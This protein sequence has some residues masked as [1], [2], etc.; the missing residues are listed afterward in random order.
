MALS[1]YGQGRLLDLKP[2]RPMGRGRGRYFPAAAALPGL[3]P[4]SPQPCHESRSGSGQDRHGV[5]GRLRLGGGGPSLGVP[6][7]AGP[8]GGE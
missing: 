1:A 7:G 5:A 8:E 6:S 2:E 4:V 3:P